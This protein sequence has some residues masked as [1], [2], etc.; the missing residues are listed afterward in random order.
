MSITTRKGMLKQGEHAAAD[1]ITGGSL[2][3]CQAGCRAQDS[4]NHN[5]H[6]HG[7]EHYA[8][9]LSAHPIRDPDRDFCKFRRRSHRSPRTTTTTTRRGRLTHK[10]GWAQAQ[11]LL[12]SRFKRGQYI[13]FHAK[14][15]D[16]STAQK[17]ARQTHPE[18]NCQRTPLS[19][20]PTAISQI[21]PRGP[22]LP[23]S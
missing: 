17:D 2:F 15:K 20:R 21:T 1:F 4:I 23:R 19:K 6:K 16:A 10:R 13:L 7:G 3:L 11:P 18:K 8:V 14:D 22:A 12:L 5:Q 9:R